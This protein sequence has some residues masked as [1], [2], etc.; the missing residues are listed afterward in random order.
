MSQEV[1]KLNN[2]VLKLEALTKKIVKEQ[3]KDQEEIDTE[4]KD[5][6]AYWIEEARSR[7]NPEY[8]GPDDEPD[9]LDDSNPRDRKVIE[10]MTN[11]AN[12][13]LE[14][15][16]D[17]ESSDGSTDGEDEEEMEEEEGSEGSETGSERSETGSE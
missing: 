2:R 4:A 5:R 8:D 13:Y 6:F 7:F 15:I 9:D 11:L 10:S 3:V 12:D 17:Y 16:V 1:K 14:T